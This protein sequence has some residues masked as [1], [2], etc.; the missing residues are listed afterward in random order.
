MEVYPDAVKM[1]KQMNYANA[2][3]AAYVAL[4]GENEMAEGRISVKNMETG[5]QQSLSP[6]ELTALLKNS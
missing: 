1:K 2:R 3:R 6:E 4:V 5:G